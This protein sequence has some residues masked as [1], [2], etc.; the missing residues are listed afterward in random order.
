MVNKD[1]L[2]VFGPAYLD[3]V[4]EIDTPL[5]S[6]APALRLDQ[7]LPASHAIPRD[8]GQILLKGP[9]GDCL[10]FHLPQEGIPAAATYGLVEPVLARLLGEQT[11][12]TVTGDYCVSIF[13]S[14]LGGMGAGY[15]KAFNGLLRLP[16]GRDVTG[17]RI[18]QELEHQQIR[19]I[20]HYLDCDTDSSLV[21]L[22]AQ[23]DK[24]AVGVREAMVRWRTDAED[25]ALVAQATALVF[26]GAPNAL[27]AEVLAW[28]PDCPVMCAPAMRNVRDTDVPLAELA[29]HIHYLTLNALEWE[30][31]AGKE[32][33]RTA[34]P[35]ITVTEGARGSRLLPRD[36]EEIFIP[37]IPSS[38][39]VNTN[40]AGETYG[41]T[42]FKTLL[43]EAPDF[44][45]SGRISRALARQAGEFATMQAA[46]QLAITGFAF[47]PDDGMA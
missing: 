25:R 27:M 20:P 38:G 30:H 33:C 31:L 46:R 39:D 36:S 16:L 47:P 7:S 35:L 42:V 6:G 4:L 40:R 1:H 10:C 11:P 15:A 23:G 22:S 41:A 8:D 32:C 12:R 29:P 24:L 45:R 37:A 28:G 2:L 13:R 43:R 26:C 17:R 18:E 44:Y 9:T 19:A 5:I 21:I 3:I 34:I 14:Q